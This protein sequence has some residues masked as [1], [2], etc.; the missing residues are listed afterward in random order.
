MG[1]MVDSKIC[2]QYMA[3]PEILVWKCFLM[4]AC[5]Y[6]TTNNNMEFLRFWIFDQFFLKFQYRYYTGITGI[7]IFQYRNT[8]ID[9]FQYRNTDIEKWSRYWMH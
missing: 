2:A 8:G 1:W 6:P 9:I 4:Y 7:D 3:S 5:I